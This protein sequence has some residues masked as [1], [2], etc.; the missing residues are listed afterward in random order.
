MI[1]LQESVEDEEEIL[2]SC[3]KPVMHED[4]ATVCGSTLTRIPTDMLTRISF[5]QLG[6]ILALCLIKPSRVK[7]TSVL[8]GGL[9]R[10]FRFHINKSNH[11]WSLKSEYNKN[12]SGKKNR[13]NFAKLQYV[14]V[15]I[16]LPTKELELLSASHLSP[17]SAVFDLQPVLYWAGYSPL[18]KTP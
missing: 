12:K 1:F 3:I 4:W 7:E 14:N 15:A 16:P 13:L 9:L 5:L 17:F 8:V 2:A 6:Q 10:G 18:K 11:C